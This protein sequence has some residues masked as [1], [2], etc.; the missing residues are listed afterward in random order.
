MQIDLDPEAEALVQRAMEVEGWPTPAVAVRELLAKYAVEPAD[1]EPVEQEE[2]RCGF[3]ANE[4]AA[5]IEEGEA[6]PGIEMTPE[7]LGALMDR[8]IAEVV[9]GR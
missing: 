5:L 2:R 3:T 9:A 1:E 4:L 8:A 6:S 7:E